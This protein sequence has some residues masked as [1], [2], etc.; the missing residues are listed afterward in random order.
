[1][2]RVPGL[3]IVYFKAYAVYDSELGYTQGLS[4]IAASLL[5]HV[6]LFSVSS[7]SNFA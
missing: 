5:L 4:F 1:M 6:R 3:T 2:F 7:R